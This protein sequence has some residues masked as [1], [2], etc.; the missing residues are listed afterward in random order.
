MN[1]TTPSIPGELDDQLAV[2]RR[3]INIHSYGV[4]RGIMGNRV[5][6]TLPLRLRCEC[7]VPSCEEIIEINLAERR[8]LRRE[9][10][11]GFIVINAHGRSS[12]D[13]TSYEKA[14]YGVVKKRGFPQT[15]IDM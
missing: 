15:V 9:F 2:T 4:I 5:I 11:R 8:E 3:N 6:D 12:R 7:S 10:P 1:N 14:N 13:T